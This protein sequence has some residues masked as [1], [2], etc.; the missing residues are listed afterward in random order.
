M[1]T[2]LLI[3]LFLLVGCAVG[4][5]GTGFLGYPDDRTRTIQEEHP[6]V[7]RSLYGTVTMTPVKDVTYD[8]YQRAKQEDR[9]K[10]EERRGAFVYYA[11]EREAPTPAAPEGPNSY[12]SP[13]YKIT[14]RFRAPLQ[15]Q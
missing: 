5:S 8:Q 3:S 2:L 11:T 15:G 12:A 6:E 10:H 9:I 4:S 7:D 13:F 1:R 14:E